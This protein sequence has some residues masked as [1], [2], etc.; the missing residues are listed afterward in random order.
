M[1]Y[2]YGG[3]GGYSYGG[4]S[5]SNYNYYSSYS[6]SYYC[7]PQPE[8]EMQKYEFTAFDE[9]SLG[10]NVKCGA[11]FTMPG[12][13]TTCITVCDDDGSLSGDTCWNENANDRTGQTATIDQGGSEAGN[14]GQIYAEVYH[15]LRGSDGKTYYLIEIEQEGTC[16][17]YFTFYGDVPP[18]GVTLC[19]VNTCNLSSVS[20]SKLGA[21]E[22]TPPNAD[23][24]AMDD[25]AKTCADEAVTV[26][27]LANDTDADGNA[28]TVTSISDADETV[29]VGGTLTLASGAKVTLNADGTVTYDAAGAHDDLLIGQQAIEEAIS[30]VVDDGNGGTDTADLDI[31]VCGATSTLQM[32]CDA[33]PDQVQLSISLTGTPLDYQIT[34]VDGAGSADDGLASAI[35]TGACID[36]EGQLLL[37]TPLTANVYGP[38][39]TLPEGLIAK[40]ENLD[41]ISWLLNQQ[42]LGQDNMGGTDTYDIFD[43]QEAVW[44]LSDGTTS[45]N[46]DAN[47][48]AQK[49]LADGEGFVAGEGDLIAVV[50][51]PISPDPTLVPDTQTFIMGV[52]WDA[53]ELDCIC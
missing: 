36:I 7:A 2:Y 49:A 26:D 45:T 43:I 37:D 17:D 51:D 42:F 5:Y 22:C 12:A 4:Y 31:T 46:A 13:A 28:L 20:Y 14:G 38:C 1:T 32:I 29:G 33:L 8:P 40:P 27:L 23:P 52:A 15:T 10:G 39:D 35:W 21:G 24:E 50:F 11:V 18:A 34:V 30:Y 6:Y 53:V 19:V 3:Y 48:I 44:I 47:E 16:D 41:N 25:M 9:A